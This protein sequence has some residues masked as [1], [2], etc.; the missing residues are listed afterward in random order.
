[1]KELQNH[2]QNAKRRQNARLEADMVE[3]GRQRSENR[4]KKKL[5]SSTTAGVEMRKKLEAAVMQLL[6]DAMKPYDEQGKGNKPRWYKPFK[7]VR[8]DLTASLAVNCFIDAAAKN[9][10]LTKAREQTAK[11]FVAL[12]YE[13]IVEG[14]AQKRREYMAFKKKMM[15]Q[16][17]DAY[18][19]I[20]LFHARAAKLGFEI[21]HYQKKSVLQALGAELM[22]YVMLAGLTHYK[23]ER[24][25]GDKNK[26]RY[27]VLSDEIRASL[28]ARN[29]TLDLMSPYYSLMSTQPNEWRRHE[30]GWSK[31]G[32]YNSN[33]LNFTLHAVRH[34]GAAQKQEVEDMIENGK[35][36]ACLDALHTIQ[37]TPYRINP[38]VVE[39]IQWVKDNDKTAGLDNWPNI[40]QLETVS[41]N[42]KDYT[43]GERVPDE[44]WDAL[45]EDSQKKLRKKLRQARASNLAA[46][47]NTT[48][49]TRYVNADPEALG[50]T[51]RLLDEDE[52]FMPHNWDNRGRVYPVNTMSHH[53]SD[54]IRAMFL[55]KN[56]WEVTEDNVDWLILQMANTYGNKIDKLTGEEKAQWVAENEE[57]I[58]LCGRDIAAS[59]DIWSGAEEP[60]QFLAA[61]HEYEKYEDAREFGEK[62]RSSLPIAVDAS[63]SGVQHFA[64]SLLNTEDAKRVNLSKSDERGDIYEDCL[65]V[66]KRLMKEDYAHKQLLLT[67]DPVTEDDRQAFRDFEK[68]LADKELDDKARKALRRRWN[69]SAPRRRLKTEKEL[70]VIQQVW[71]WSDPD[72]T[73]PYGRS[74][75][76]RN[77]MTYCYSS[78]K[79]GF[80]QQLRSDW[81]DKLSELVRLQRLNAHPFGE[82]EG[83][84]ACTYIADVH[85]R[86]IE[87]VVVSAKVGMRF[88]QKI[89]RI[90]ATY[91]MEQE[92]AEV[93]AD[94]VE[95]EEEASVARKKTHNS[96]GV[97]L[98]FLTPIGF[99]F[100]QHYVKEINLR[101]ECSFYDIE[102]DEYRTDD[103]SYKDEDP[104]YLWVEKS[105]NASAPNLIHAM[106][107]TH[108]MMT[109]NDCASQG[110]TD[111]MVVHDSFATGI[112]NMGILS[113]ALRD[114]IVELYRDYNLYEDLL[115]QAKA[116]HPDPDSV[117]W[118]TPPKRGD[119]DIEEVYESLHSFS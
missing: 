83:F 88:I 17:G 51:Q 8:P 99:P 43:V 77:V 90:L 48:N 10:T 98:R 24:K 38:Y 60:F 42:G 78:R 21:E 93:D 28:D 117:Q 46:D 39:A 37:N 94:A 16:L 40:K 82:D 36:N 119:F 109:V 18:R 92:E 102:I 13:Q 65:V 32:A 64:L 103:V 85:E 55:F 3:R 84:A 86:A 71:D 87:E 44:D 72:L 23:K 61:C 33:R 74:V 15:E 76:K 26:T 66:A 58:R 6:L 114:N 63:Q 81:M 110:V 41:F 91:K 89:V 118:P 5:A 111:L 104:N 68:Q 1:M 31:S 59:Y 12:L 4:R 19:R 70:E 49:L 9:W 47:G 107:A 7:A 54:Y 105:V 116:I 75:I 67:N 22:N 108:L 25:E 2:P 45:S 73:K 79:F 11:A 57:A 69:R 62:Y 14:N 56:D 101:T 97:H 30:D 96:D 27:L 115:E 35:M 52:L 106:D 20:D 50:E 80:A 29:K 34:M 112:G 95:D 53:D 100:H 113:R